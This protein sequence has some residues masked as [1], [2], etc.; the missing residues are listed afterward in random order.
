MKLLLVIV[1][2]FGLAL[3]ACKLEASSNSPKA[4]ANASPS[5]IESTGTA[6]QEPKSNCSLTRATVPVVEGLKLGMTP[7]EL[8]A[9]LPGSKDDPEVKSGL[10]RPASALGEFDFVVHTDK[11]QPKEKFEGI[12]HF[13]F[14]LLDGRASS[15]NIGY[16]GPAYS[17]VDEFVTKFVKGTNLPPVDQWQG[18]PG[19]DTQLKTLVCKDFEVRVFAGGEGGNQ[20]YVLLSDLEAK[21]TL[22]DRRAK[23]RAQASPTTSP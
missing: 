13:T 11:L 19:M 12:D 18:Y 1:C 9:A 14:G 5:P 20:N 10:A 15:I 23:A 4:N 8:V 17:H 6:S 22:K 2:L 3:T 16:K 21:K 7:D